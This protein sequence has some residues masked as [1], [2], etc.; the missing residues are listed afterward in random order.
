HVIMVLV[1]VANGKPKHVPYRDSRLTF[2]L[3]DSLGGNSKTVI[4]A[5]VSP[6][7]CAAAETLNTL[8]FAQRAKLIQNNAVVNEDSTGDVIAL[9]RQICLLQEE[10]AALKRQNVS[11][12]LSFGSISIDDDMELEEEVPLE[13][14]GEEGSQRAEELLGF[15]SKGVVRM[16]TKQLKSLET[17]LAGALRREQMA[18]MSIKQLEAEIEQLNRLVHQREEDTRCTK[19][20]LKFREDKIQRMESLTAGSIN[21]ESYLREENK[22]LAEEIQLLQAKVDKNPEVTRFALENIRLL[23]QLRRFQEF[24][25]E[26]ERDILLQEV[27]KLRDQLLQFIDANPEQHIYL[28]LQPQEAVHLSK[29]NGSLHS[30]LKNTQNEL[31]ECRNNLTSCLQENAKL[32]REIQDLRSMFDKLNAQENGLAGNFKSTK[33]FPEEIVELQLEL[34]IL[35][36]LLQE[37]RVSRVESEERAI[38]LSRDLEMM[39]EKLSSTTKLFEEVNSELHEAKSVIQA[40]ESEQVL[41]INELEDLKNSNNQYTKL[42]SLKEVEIAA[43]K[44]QISSSVILRDQPPNEKVQSDESPLRFRLNRMHQS[45]EK[46]KQLNLW[47][48]SDLAF[49]ASN[50]EEMDQVRGQVE[51]E[52]AEVIVCM[53]EELALLQ[54]QIRDSELKEIETEKK[55]IFLENENRHLSELL[56]EKEMELQN[57]SEEWKLLTTEIEEV[58]GDGHESL[59]VASDELDNINSSFPQRR[60]LI[61]EHLDQMVRAISEKE[62]VIEELSS[63]LEEANSKR[64]NLESMLKSL[65]GAALVITE[66]H[67]QEC[68]EKEKEIR[69]LSSQLNGKSYEVQR[70][71]ERLKLAK[72]NMRNASTCATAAFVVVSRLSEV[73]FN[74]LS[75]LK[76]KDSELR[77]SV[78]MVMK[79]DLLLDEQAFKI[80]ELEKQIESLRQALSGEKQHVNAMKQR[81]EDVEEGNILQARH[82]LEK[83]NSGTCTLRSSM[84]TLLDDE[85]H[86]ERTNDKK[87]DTF[88]HLGEERE[89]ETENCQEK[90]TDLG[91]VEGPKA[92]DCDLPCKEGQLGDWY[93]REGN[94]DFGGSYHGEYG[95]D[96]TIL[97]LKR[98]VGSALESLKHMQ[99]EMAKLQI[100]KEERQLSEK[101]ERENMNHLAGQVLSLQEV[102][103]RFEDE[104]KLKI[105][106]FYSKVQTFELMMLDVGNDWCMVKELLEQEVGDAE[107]AAAEKSAEASFDLAKFTE[108]QDTLKE[109]DVLIN[110]LTIANETMKLEVERLK[111]SETSLFKERDALTEEI[112]NL[113]SINGKRDQ[114]LASLEEQ[115][116]LHLMETGNLFAEV[117]GIV[118]ELAK[119]CE[120]K[121]VLLA[122][123]FCPVKSSVF[124]SVKLVK[125][126]FEE[127]WSEIIVRDCALSSLHLCHMGI[128]LETVTGL[129]AENGLL[130]HGLC[131]TDSL[132]S[133]L[134]EQNSR[135]RRE[136]EACRFL[137]GKLLAD[138]KN[139]FDRI[140]RK[141]KEAVDL[142]CR[143]N[144][145]ERKILELQ[146]QEEMMLQRSD[147]IGSQLAVLM[148]EL[149]L[150]NLSA[151]KLLKEEEELLNSEFE[152]FELQLCS[153][154]F[155]SVIL[156]REMEE[157]AF[158]KAKLVDNLEKLS[159]EMILSGIDAEL[160]ELLLMEHDSDNSTMQRAL[161]E[162]ERERQDLSMK[163]NE[164]SS[165]ILEMEGVI[166]NLQ[167][168]V[169]LLSE[170]NSLNHA[171]E[172]EVREITG[173]K[174]TLMSRIQSLE[175]EREQL[176]Y[177][178]GRRDEE[179]SNIIGLREE[180]ES[181]KREM[182]EMKNETSVVLRDLAEKRSE[183]ESSLTSLERLNRETLQLKDKIV[184]LETNI[185]GLSSDLEVK[186]AELK[187]LR[188]S[189]SLLTEELSQ[190]TRKLEANE[191]FKQ[192]FLFQSNLNTR[193]CTQLVK[194]INA[195]HSILFDLLERRSF[196]LADKMFQQICEDRELGTKFMG[197]FMS[198]DSHIEELMS[199]NLALRAELSRKDSILE[200]LSFDLRLLQ[201][202]T[203]IC[204][205]QKDEMEKM[206]ASVE[207]LEDELAMKSDELDAVEAHAEMLKAQVLEKSDTI[208][209]LE[210]DLVK[211]RE[212]VRYLSEE[213][214]GLKAS[215]EEALAAK[216]SSEEELAERRKLNESLEMELSDVTDTVNQLNAA[217][218]YLKTELNE[219]AFERD[220]LQAKA[221]D[222]KEKLQKTQTVAEKYE[223]VAIE[224]QEM[225][226]ARESYAQDKEEEVKLL[227]LSVR[228]LGCTVD[229]LENKVDIVKG[230]AER[231]RLLREE[232]ESELHS[233]KNQIE[234]FKN[235]DADMKM[236]LDEKKADLEKALKQIQILERDIAKKEL[237]ISNCRSHISELNLHAEAQASEYKQKFKAL[238]AMAEQVRAEAASTQASN[239]IPQKLE[240]N[241]SRPRGSGS[242]FKCIGLGLAQQ[243]KSEKDEDLISAR[244]RIDE[245]E[246]A[247]A[248]K[249]KEIFTLNAKLAAAESMTHD[250]IRDLLG[251]KLDV[252]SYVSLLHTQQEEKISGKPE[253]KIS[254]PQHEVIRLKEQLNEFI[255]ERQGWLDE[256]DRR[257]AEL[258]AAQVALESLRQRDQLLKTEN[259]MLKVEN[260]NYKKM[261]MELEEE[262]SRL[263][264]QQNLQQRIHHHAK[265]KEENN[266]LKIQNEELSNKLRRAEFVLS[267]VKE[268]LARYR[269]SIGKNPYVN[270]DEEQLLNNKLKETEEERVQLAQKLLGLCTSVLKVAGFTRPVSKVSPSI[271]EEAL[272]QLK[273]KLDL[274]A[275][276]L[277]DLKTKVNL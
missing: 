193:N 116:G 7:I 165:K 257:Q 74:H 271:A 222:L 107:M 124:D 101:Q 84:S 184:F 231:Q 100:E 198:L 66:A 12:S 98:E 275:S 265:I 273:K 115:I 192:E 46:A 77:E 164:S 133:D 206:V 43:L 113:Q 256:M 143:I 85:K 26:G 277:H 250:V 28:S 83:L 21:S 88:F 8:K 58:L 171:L 181:L 158:Q 180:H 168:D 40:L 111:R 89:I 223:A 30:E 119:T 37:E 147:S 230:E 64:N 267:R 212:P 232:L 194:N 141:E 36:I 14:K 215:I 104:S 53:Q 54:Q 228:E 73:N 151:A 18:D 216:I 139:G 146:L 31:E 254:E 65:R 235:A 102:M 179:L 252:T 5:N 270:L 79:K 72:D 17:T 118:A 186:N 138:I 264:G 237:E 246:S 159:R 61:S 62:V 247:V 156:T 154:E 2:L 266:M 39:T 176:R 13:N 78:E 110:G 153:K 33:D 221:L 244:L 126:W 238:E 191:E 214:V 142:S 45:L 23:D 127:I 197:E 10:L 49:Q 16:S 129:N 6:S 236:H 276:E 187:E 137:E 248:S 3:Q 20:M 63:C 68:R 166:R 51:A 144:G 96:A 201:E 48:Q 112:H 81:L 67:Q 97:M 47:Y 117:E 123:E 86:P 109:A 132:L 103:N 108:A 255:M 251:V 152:K 196:T 253:G 213:N 122:D 80:E 224:A 217:V 209:L 52:T 15:E 189:Q 27:S 11:R 75:E 60:F 120:E 95:R 32:S 190:K 131:Q 19:M 239:S 163:L 199:E 263:S 174:L 204:Q 175:G 169:Q 76:Q 219:L 211:E 135:S 161:E 195:S 41:S 136:L 148:K 173:T 1:D 114:Q 268:E 140:S 91:L 177:E 210:L 202:S 155:E 272:E 183:C 234:K 260:S 157:T 69:L 149:D 24:Y 130:Q 9:Q 25:E 4:V 259:D 150:S 90:S 125:S 160:E 258:V 245:L 261:V 167:Q 94:S 203:S 188:D 207:A 240:K 38:C 29:E 92:E 241:S 274:M 50:E 249:Q 93:Q 220:Q 162:R 82:M 105:E 227:E 121:F 226:E 145:F 229:A 269:A 200:G 170:V 42:L 35:K 185:S 99:V 106:T 178:L 56:E 243:I 225:A 55:T 233:V 59:V 87:T 70:L 57:L 71:K 262:T 134:R 208:A 182:A 218:E 242:P 128:L 22:A 205:D 34:D 44:K 172:A